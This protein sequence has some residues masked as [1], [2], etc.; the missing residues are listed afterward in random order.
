VVEEYVEQIEV[1]VEPRQF[2]GLKSE[3]SSSPKSVIEVE[4]EEIAE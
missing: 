3:D 2:Q 1:K 4:V